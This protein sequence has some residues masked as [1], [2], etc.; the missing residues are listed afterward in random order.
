M[1][2]ILS[3]DDITG[4]R[5]T[6]D[7]PMTPEDE[8]QI[9]STGSILPFLYVAHVI[10]GIENLRPIDSMSWN[11]VGIECSGGALF[12]TIKFSEKLL[13]E[14]Y[15]TQILSYILLDPKSNF[16]CAACYECGMQGDDIWFKI[17]ENDYIR[18]YH[19]L[20]DD[21]FTTDD[22][23]IPYRS[24]SVADAYELDPYLMESVFITCD[25]PESNCDDMV[26]YERAKEAAKGIAYLRH[27][28]GDDY[29]DYL[30]SSSPS[31]NTINGVY[32]FAAIY[33]AEF[34]F[35]DFKSLLDGFAVTGSGCQD[36]L[37]WYFMNEDCQEA[38]FD[39]ERD[40]VNKAFARYWL[41]FDSC[42][43]YDS[44]C[45]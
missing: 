43:W 40:E 17:D 38:Y 45:G 19:D 22:C 36:Y 11:G 42:S 5:I 32:D 9:T 4:I 39:A 13:I 35:D 41:Y 7:D 37:H 26:D 33:S 12:G 27:K 1:T 16:D 30:G 14:A 25:E 6:E 34:G 3:K 8:S 2:A 44:Y 29:Y 18:G 23:D 21:S 15:V 20:Y 24:L 10:T 31:N 28:M